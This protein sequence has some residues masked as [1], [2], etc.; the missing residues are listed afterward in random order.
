MP[1]KGRS[2]ESQ[3][4]KAG[5][6]PGGGAQGMPQVWLPDQVCAWEE[7][8]AYSAILTAEFTVFS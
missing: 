6:K 2:N 5:N 7:G 3:P 1:K 8:T 4:P